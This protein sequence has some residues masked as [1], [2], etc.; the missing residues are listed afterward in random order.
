MKQA[1]GHLEETAKMWQSQ[2]KQFETDA[3]TAHDFHSAAKMQI[4][5]V[6]CLFMIIKNIVSETN[7]ATLFFLHRNY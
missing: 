7:V 6:S 2:L 1:I 5:H 3:A 4:S